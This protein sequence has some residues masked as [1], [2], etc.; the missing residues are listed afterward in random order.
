[1]PNRKNKKTRNSREGN[2]NAYQ[3][4]DAPLILQP[5]NPVIRRNLQSY[6]VQTSTAGGSL[7]TAIDI[8]SALIA[9]TDWTNM[10][11]SYLGVKVLR[12]AIEIVPFIKMYT[13]G[14]NYYHPNVC[15]GYNPSSYAAPGSNYVVLNNACSQW[16]LL[17]TKH[18][19]SF[20]PQIKSGA[21]GA[22]DV[23]VWNAGNVLGSLQ[24]YGSS[25]LPAST[26]V[27]AV[28]FVFTCEFVNPG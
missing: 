24:L 17:N 5:N 22:I 14:A 9:S 8:T 4:T 12:V 23:T 2:Q 26:T 1:M 27:L 18:Q 13:S 28:R 15:V 11:G 7:D 10:S 3:A 6:S 21:K 25:S 19:M 16:L 20:T